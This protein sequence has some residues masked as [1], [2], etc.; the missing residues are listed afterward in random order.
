MSKELLFSITKK[1]FDIQ[2]FRSG[3]KGGQHQNKTES[4]VRIIHRESGA[5]GESREERS[6]AQNKKNA[7]NRLVKSEKFKNFI[8]LKASKIAHDK[9]SIEEVVEKMMNDRYIKV[10]VVKNGSWK[11]VED[12]G[13]CE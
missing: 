2:T 8:K 6:Q 5:I 3:G 13:E 1:D 12:I 7:F 10:E 9:E 11:E 4:G